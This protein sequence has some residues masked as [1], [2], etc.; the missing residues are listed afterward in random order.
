[1]SHALPLSAP[2]TFRMMRSSR[3]PADLEL[4][5]LKED[6]RRQII[7]AGDDVNRDGLL[8]T[9]DRGTHRSACCAVG[10]T[11]RQASGSA[12]VRDNK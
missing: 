10:E 11:G 8:K 9:P 1:M 2:A 7:S 4:E 6:Y 5:Q 3:P 12:S